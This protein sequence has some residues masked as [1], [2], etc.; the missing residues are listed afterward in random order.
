LPL[1]EQGSDLRLQAGL[2]RRRRR[3]LLGLVMLMWGLL[4]GVICGESGV[5]VKQPLRRV[6]RP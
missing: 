4:C 6:P 5:V 3:L 1:L 2:Q